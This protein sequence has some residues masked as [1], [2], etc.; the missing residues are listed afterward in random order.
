M[1]INRARL[2]AGETV[3]VL[4]AGSG[5]GSAAIQIAKLFH[6]RVITTAGNDAKL[7]KARELGADEVINHTTQ[8]IAAEVRR[9]TNKR[10]VDV[11]IEHVGTATWQ[12]SFMSLGVN[13]R[14]VTCGNTT[15]YDAAIDLR[16]LFNR[17]LSLLGSF[18]GRSD[19]L[20]AALPFFAQ[21]K[22]KAVVDRVFPLSE[23][24]WAHEYL[25]GREQFGKVLLKP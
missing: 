23:A 2:Q 24:G 9:L 21:R 5:V 12:K 15:G 16:Y 1:L 20:L 25:D 10:G 7:A 17:H 6:C 11:V 22:L 4:G 3:L 19:E 18:M 8:D 13:G 14:L